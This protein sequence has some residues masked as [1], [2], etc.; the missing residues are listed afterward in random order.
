MEKNKTQKETTMWAK[1]K[2]LLHSL[3]PVQRLFLTLTTLI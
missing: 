3:L 2:E 1:E